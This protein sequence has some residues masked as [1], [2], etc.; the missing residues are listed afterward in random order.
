MSSI[1]K[2]AAGPLIILYAVNIICSRASIILLVYLLS[3][4]SCVF[5][6]E[7]FQSYLNRFAE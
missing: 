3:F 4:I 1:L 5:K 2:T 6:T 7:F